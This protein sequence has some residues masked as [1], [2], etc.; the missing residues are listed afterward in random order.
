MRAARS[1]TARG[2]GP[3]ERQCAGGS[4]RS[5]SGGTGGRG[6]W[7]RLREHFGREA[8]EGRRGRLRQQG[9]WEEKGTWEPEESRHQGL[10]SARTVFVTNPQPGM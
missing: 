10:C 1:S 8:A 7:E 6:Q 9:G 5:T 3:G 2:E 4:D